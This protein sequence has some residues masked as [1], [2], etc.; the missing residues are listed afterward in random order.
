MGRWS[1]GTLYL[2]VRRRG[3]YLEK[4]KGCG[5]RERMEECRD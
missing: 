2:D 3:S 5:G 1:G 4:G